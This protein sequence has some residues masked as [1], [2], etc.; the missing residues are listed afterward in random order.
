M[1]PREGEDLP[2]PGHGGMQQQ[3]GAPAK[4]FH[5]VSASLDARNTGPLRKDQDS[6]KDGSQ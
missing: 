4:E 3:C 2:G 1:F 6:A 5:W